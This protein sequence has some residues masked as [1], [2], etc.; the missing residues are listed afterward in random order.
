[1]PAYTLSVL[2]QSPIAEGRSAADA[3]ADTLDLA[4][5]CDALGYYRYWVAEHHASPALAG[6]APEVLIGPIAQATKKIRVGSGGI[7]L[8]HYSPF[9]VAE[10]F[11]LLSALAPGRI[12]LGIGRAPGGDGRTMIA[13]QRDR[14]RR[15]PHDDFPNN[16]AE[17]VDHFAGSLPDDHPFAPLA[18]TLPSGGGMPEIWL[19]GSSMDSAL[20]AGEAGLPYCF[21]DFINRDGAA[22]ASAY[23]ERFQPSAALAEPWVMVASWA[24]AAEDHDEAV[25]LGRPGAMLGA[26]L[27]R[28]VL[29]PVPTIETAEGWLAEHP[30][31]TARRRR[32]IVGTP[33]EVR[34]GIDEAAEEYGADEMMLV[35][36]MSDHA[37]R[38]QSYR[39]IAGE[40]GL[41][42]PGQAA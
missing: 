17:L 27:R 11:G 41:A 4:R 10:V 31:A 7:M 37:A 26:L 33:R 3:L 1:M 23:R 18:E 36:I 24:I 28:N 30:E 40:Y 15:M 38:R 14:S 13:L 16:L 2:D 34:A 39:L 8:P 12:D 25:R 32:A 5:H 35:N 21:A 6:A 22:I 42:E 20:W 19:L 9:K 29:I